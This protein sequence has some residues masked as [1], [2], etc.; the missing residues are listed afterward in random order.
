MLCF[1]AEIIEKLPSICSPLFVNLFI[2]FP[3]SHIFFLSKINILPRMCDRFVYCKTIFNNCTSALKK[4]KKHEIDLD[5]WDG[6][7]WM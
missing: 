1:D 7:I 2:G 3:I 5:R 4:P 6:R